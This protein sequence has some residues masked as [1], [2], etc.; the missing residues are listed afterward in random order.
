V[1]YL[2]E[3]GHSKEADELLMRVFLHNADGL[4]ELVEY[5]PEA[6]FVPLF[7]ELM[8]QRTKMRQEIKE[9]KSRGK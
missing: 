2:W 8:E 1:A 5:Y 7:I 6:G 9:S 4:D 3:L